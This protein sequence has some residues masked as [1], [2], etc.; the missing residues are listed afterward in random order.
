MFS[1]ISKTNAHVW[2]LC[3]LKISRRTFGWRIAEFGSVGGFEIFHII[4]ELIGLSLNILLWGWQDFGWSLFCEFFL[5]RKERTLNY[6]WS[7]QMTLFGRLRS[8]FYK[9]TITNDVALIYSN[10][11]IILN[12]LQL[13]SR[14]ISNSRPYRRSLNFS[15]VGRLQIFVRLI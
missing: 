2:L 15:A 3:F 6:I 7:I 9:W 12:N 4:G 11:E 14:L 5:S 1:A 13:I 10:T 8:N